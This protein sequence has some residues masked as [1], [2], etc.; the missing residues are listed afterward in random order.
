MLLALAV[1]EGGE[2][3]LVVGADLVDVPEDLGD[4]A[5]EAGLGD[6][7]GLGISEGFDKDLGARSQREIGW[8][9]R[10]T[11]IADELEVGDVVTL[12]GEDLP[13][14]GLALDLVLAEGVNGL[15][16]DEAVPLLIL[17]WDLAGLKAAQALFRVETMTGKRQRL[18]A[19]RIRGDR[20]GGR[21]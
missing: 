14:D 9:A 1:K 5:A 2:H 10:T 3:A 12:G 20:R 7:L 17:L 4:E 21:T 15:G 6:D 13:D 11:H 8:G 18:F 16:R 19:P